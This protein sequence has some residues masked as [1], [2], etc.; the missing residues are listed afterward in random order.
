MNNSSITKEGKTFYSTQELADL[1]KVSRITIFNK[2]KSGRISAQKIGRNYLIPV[3][4]VAS[5]LE[6]SENEVL[7]D[8]SKAEIAEAVEKVVKEYG[9]ALKLLGKE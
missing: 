5:L 2:I 4:S 6:S 3:S 9:Q 8:K 1:L 7:T